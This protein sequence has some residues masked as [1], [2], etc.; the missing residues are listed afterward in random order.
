MKQ[1]FKVFY[2]RDKMALKPTVKDYTDL[3]NGKLNKNLTPAHVDSLIKIIT[4]ET[5]QTIDSLKQ[6]K[7]E[8][9]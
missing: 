2:L 5:K 4:E 1:L 6:F 8:L 3:V 7:K 9:K